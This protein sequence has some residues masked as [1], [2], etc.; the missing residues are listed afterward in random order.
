MAFNIDV[1]NLQSSNAP[2]AFGTLFNNGGTLAPG[3]SGTPGKT[4]ITGNLTNY[5][6]ALAIDLGGNVQATAFQNGLTNYDYVS[7]T[8]ATLLGGSLNVSLINGLSPAATDSFTILDSAGG[9]SGTF[10]NLFASNRVAVVGNP[11][12]SF[13]VL[14]TATSVI[15]TN[16]IQNAP[17]VTVS[18]NST[19]TVYGKSIL[20]TANVGNGKVVT[21]D[22]SDQHGLRHVRHGTE[23]APICGVSK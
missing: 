3:D 23:G 15:L 7:V 18:P 17:T 8:G 14:V 1:S 4:T 19:N 20:L 9:V 12:V 11:N 22:R 10:T 5:S 2:G 16:L 6:G 21:R 13:Q